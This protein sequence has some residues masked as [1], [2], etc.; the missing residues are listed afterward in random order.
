MLVPSISPVS[1]DLPAEEVSQQQT[2]T[3]AVGKFA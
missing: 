3:R 1:L 2:L